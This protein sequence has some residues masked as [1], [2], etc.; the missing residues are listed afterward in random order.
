MWR[1]S[2]SFGESSARKQLYKVSFSLVHPENKGN[3]QD[4]FP[5]KMLDVHLH[6]HFLSV[7]WVRDTLNLGS[8]TRSSEEKIRILS[9]LN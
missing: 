9:F 8:L 6:N 7:S 3:W 2:H 5:G 4:S 1:M